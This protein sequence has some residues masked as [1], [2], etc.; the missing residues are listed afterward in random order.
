ML[1]AASMAACSDPAAPEIEPPVIDPC[2]G[3][4]AKT[5]DLRADTMIILSVLRD[6]VR[7]RDVVMPDVR[8]VIRVTNMGDTASN[9][10]VFSHEGT[11]DT[12]P[13]IAAKSSRTDTLHFMLK[14]ADEL[15]FA[16]PRTLTVS[17]SSAG[18]AVGERNSVASRSFYLGKATLVA[19]SSGAPPGGPFMINKRFAGPYTFRNDGYAPSP[20]LAVNACLQDNFGSC[21]PDNWTTIARFDI[22]ALQ[23][24]Q[25]FVFADSLTVPLMAA[26]QDE[27]YRY[28]LVMCLPSADPNYT[29]A[30]FCWPSGQLVLQPDYEACHPPLLAVGQTN[31]FTSFNCGLRPGPID[32]PVVQT[33]R[34]F[35]IAAL[36]VD[37]GRTYRIEGMRADIPLR[38]YDANGAQV[39]DDDEAPDRFNIPWSGRVYI[40]MYGGN[41]LLTVTVR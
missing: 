29:D 39:Q 1:C 20:A 40:V 26:Y 21:R 37:A 11:A 17:L 2:V 28:S 16:N 24:G 8:V 35:H 5:F 9:S 31:A 12:L 4:V 36:N 18:E 14:G 7:K 33:D 27:E 38:I 19:S 32:N 34:A 25:Q 15:R 22:P 23:P 3:C 30:Q 6:S 41:P 10:V 13:P